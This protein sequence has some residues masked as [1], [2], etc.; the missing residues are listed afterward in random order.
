MDPHKIHELL[1]EL[2]L[3]PDYGETRGLPFYAEATILVKV[4]IS[5]YD[6]PVYL[7]P[8]TAKA[9]NVMKDAAQFD[10]IGLLLLSGFRSF[11]TQAYIIRSK[12]MAGRSI[13]EIMTANAPPGYSQHHS[14]RALDICTPGFIVPEQAFDKTPA[15]KWLKQ[16]ARKFGFIMSYPQKN[17]EGFI[18]EPWHWF[19]E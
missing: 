10:G 9:W 4:G 2:G 5:P 13:E 14:G 12:I 11:Q 1:K 17:R 6:K 15:F 18:Y 16:H 7:T 8:E 19:F 3:P